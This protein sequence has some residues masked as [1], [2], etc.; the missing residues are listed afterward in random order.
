LFLILSR[1]LKNKASLMQRFESGFR[2]Y[3]QKTEDMTTTTTTTDD[4]QAGDSSITNK[5]KYDKT[6]NK[7]TVTASTYV[8][9]AEEDEDPVAKERNR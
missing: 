6:S 9:N 1:A 2:P 4:E 5:N 3:I 7:Q 8:H